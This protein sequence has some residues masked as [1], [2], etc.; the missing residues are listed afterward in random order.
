MKYLLAVL[1]AACTAPQWS[2]GRS[3]D[4]VAHDKTEFLRLMP[5]IVDMS[6][7]HARAA[8]HR[9]GTGPLIV[10]VESFVDAWHAETGEA[11]SRSQI[12]AAMDR[13]FLDLSVV[14]SQECGPDGDTCRIVNNGVYVRLD[15][16]T[17]TP[18]GFDAV[19]TVDW[20]SPRGGGIDFNQIHYSFQRA[21]DGWRPTD[22]RVL[23]RS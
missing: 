1:I 8:A 19:V 14:Q 10:N 3:S 15:S 4:A 7:A 20:N 12:V 18:S 2:N 11:L 17:R 6:E 9:S 13:P 21:T 22:Q 5:M 16:I 23:V